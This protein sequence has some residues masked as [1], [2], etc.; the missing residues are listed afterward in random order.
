[1]NILKWIYRIISQILFL[2]EKR[3]RILLISTILSDQFY[4]Y[5]K[6]IINWL[7]LS[8]WLFYF[9]IS[10]S[11]TVTQIVCTCTWYR[12]ANAIDVITNGL[13]EWITQQILLLETYVGIRPARGW[14][15]RYESMEAIDKVL[16]LASKTSADRFLW[17][18]ISPFR[19]LQASNVSIDLDMW[20]GLVYSRST[21][22]ISLDLIDIYT[23]NRIPGKTVLRDKRR[24]FFH[25]DT[26]CVRCSRIAIK[27]TFVPFRA[28]NVRPDDPIFTLA[29]EPSAPSRLEISKINI[30]RVQQTLDVLDQTAWR[31]KQRIADK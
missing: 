1:M 6:L 4:L 2:V 27:I 24:K 20:N 7:S 13:G 16:S 31:V 10:T 17:V 21:A 3:L 8:Q 28:I 19:G 18:P 14:V 23:R 29:K 12:S 9:E 26:R 25:S 5:G 15:S 30:E 22:R 11:D